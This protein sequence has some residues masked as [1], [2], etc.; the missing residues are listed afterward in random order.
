MC[1]WE[2]ERFGA[3][4]IAPAGGWHHVHSTT[5]TMLVTAAKGLFSTDCVST[6]PSSKCFAQNPPRSV[7]SSPRFLIR[8]WVPEG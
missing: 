6:R 4:Q 2:G 1:D 8:F 7:S 5:V 3:I